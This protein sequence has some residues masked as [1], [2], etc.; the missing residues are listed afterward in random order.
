M[1][2]IMTH[3]VAG[4]PSL[5]ESKLLAQTMI[6]SGVSYIEIQIPF[7]DPIADGKTI[8][9]ANK[10]ALENGITPDDAFELMKDLSGKAKAHGVK[11]L[12]MSY[13]NILFKYGLE[14]FCKKAASIGC[15]G[16]I[17]P[18][19]PIDEEP[20]EHYLAICEK[21]NLHAI[22]VIAPI[23]PEKRLKGIAKHANGF[24]YCTATTGTTGA[25]AQMSQNL[26]SYIGKVRKHIPDIPIA[27]GFG[28]SSRSQVKQAL[29]HV[30]I[31]VIGSKII[32]IYNTSK[33]QNP[34]EDVKTFILEVIQ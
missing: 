6:E 5:K 31:A 1:N 30:D 26:E 9:D 15:Y 7:S 18:D 2:R 20:H 10:K 29:A 14:R 19:I 11:L 28:I 32:N 17:I 12:F 13:Y 25:R 24:V 3:I 33:K 27:L 4:Y 21:Y 22:Q 23:T 16:L 34:V 8:M